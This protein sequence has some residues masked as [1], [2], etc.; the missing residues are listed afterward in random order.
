MTNMA[1]AAETV[2][3]HVDELRLMAVEGKITEHDH[4]AIG[5]VLK[6][7]IATLIELSD[8]GWQMFTKIINESRAVHYER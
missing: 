8:E 3:R 7:N 5:A 2:Q 1:K 4:D 6:Q